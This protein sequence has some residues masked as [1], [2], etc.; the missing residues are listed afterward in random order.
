MIK[1]QSD[2]YKVR[3]QSR[4]PISEPR[5]PTPD[6]RSPN[7]DNAA[8]LLGSSHAKWSHV[9]CRSALMALFI[10]LSAPLSAAPDQAPAERSDARAY[11]FAGYVEADGERLFSLT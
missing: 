6:L 11:E 8:L 7:C 10:S 2:A 9:H 3:P 1:F 5:S 4:T